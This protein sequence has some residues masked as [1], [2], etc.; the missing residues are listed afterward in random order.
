VLSCREQGAGASCICPTIPLFRVLVSI[1]IFL[2]RALMTPE[3]NSTI[4]RP[5]QG[6]AVVV[7]E[8]N[9]RPQLF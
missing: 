3:S 1:Y 9:C 4:W 6:R 2:M 5:I 7:G 8:S